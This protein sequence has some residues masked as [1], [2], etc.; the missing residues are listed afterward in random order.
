MR[1]KHFA[2]ADGSLHEAV[3]AVDLAAAIG[4]VDTEHAQAVQALGAMTSSA[5]INLVPI[6]GLLFSAL[7]LGEPTSIA[8]VAGGALVIAGLVL[9]ERGS[10]AA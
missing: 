1:R 2:I 7:L 3:G 5:Y 9:L 10:K 8:L 6:F 4:A